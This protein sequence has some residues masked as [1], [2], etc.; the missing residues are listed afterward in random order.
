MIEPCAD[1]WPSA[2]W[3]ANQMTRGRMPARFIANAALPSSSSP[4]LVMNW[5]LPT[6]VTVRLP[7]R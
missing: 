3:G 4:S 5:L 1:V 6:T 7:S 2:C